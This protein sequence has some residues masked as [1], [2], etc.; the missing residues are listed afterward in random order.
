LLL[1][2][3]LLRKRERREAERWRGTEE[4]KELR[5]SLMGCKVREREREGRGMGGR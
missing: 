3:Y 1:L 5:K 4:C 2:I